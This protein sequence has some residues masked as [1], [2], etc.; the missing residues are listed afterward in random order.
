MLLASGTPGTAGEC[1]AVTTTQYFVLALSTVPVG[2]ANLTGPPTRRDGRVR[3]ATTVWLGPLPC[4]SVF[5][6]EAS[7]HRHLAGLKLPNKHVNAVEGVTG[8]VAACREPLRPQ[9]V[10]YG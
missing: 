8:L 6:A 1:V 3:V 9:N 4:S 5:S 2:A 10:P 7:L